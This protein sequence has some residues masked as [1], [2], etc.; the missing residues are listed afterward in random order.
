MGLK[1]FGTFLDAGLA[2]PQLRLDAPLGGGPDWP[3]YAYLAATFGSL[4]PFLEGLGVVRSDQVD[5]ASLPDQLRA[6]IVGQGGIQQLPPLI[7][8]W[9]RT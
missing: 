8:A 2:A 9:S 3:G 6:E 1:L 5:L 7:G 4:L